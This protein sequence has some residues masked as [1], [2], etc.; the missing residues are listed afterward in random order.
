MDI[1]LA[2]PCGLI[3]N[4]LI[5]NSLQH[6]FPVAREGKITIELN[7]K[8]GDFILIVRDNGIGIPDNVDISSHVTLGFYLIDLMLDQLHGKMELN[9]DHGSEITIKFPSKK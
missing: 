5:T 4:E 3:L 7:N 1:Q 8:N 9:S 6:A 2:I